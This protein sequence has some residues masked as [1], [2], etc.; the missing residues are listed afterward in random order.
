LLRLRQVQFDESKTFKENYKRLKFS[1]NKSD[2]DQTVKDLEEANHQ[3]HTIVNR[4]LTI[5]ASQLPLDFAHI[6]KHAGRLHRAL[7][8]DPSFQESF[9][10]VPPAEHS[11]RVFLDLRVRH[12]SKV[13]HTSSDNPLHKP[14]PFHIIFS[15]DVRTTWSS[16]DAD[17][18]SILDPEPL[19]T[20]LEFIPIIIRNRA[21]H[22]YALFPSQVGP[23]DLASIS[24]LDDVLLDVNLGRKRRLEIGLLAAHGLLQLAGTPWLRGCWTKNIFIQH[25]TDYIDVSKSAHSQKTHAESSNMTSS[26]S[27]TAQRTR[28]DQSYRHGDVNPYVCSGKASA[29]NISVPAPKFLQIPAPQPVPVFISPPSTDM[30]VLIASSLDSE[31]ADQEVEVKPDS[32][33]RIIRNYDLYQLGVLL[34][35]LWYGKSLHAL[36]RNEDGPLYRPAD[37]FKDPGDLH[38]DPFTEYTTADLLVDELYADAGDKYSDAV[39]R[40]IRCDFEHRS[41]DLTDPQL[42]QEVHDGVYQTLYINYNFGFGE[43]SIAKAHV[44]TEQIDEHPAAAIHG[45]GAT[46]TWSLKRTKS[47]G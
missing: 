31:T 45:S 22:I 42:L 1:L 9:R 44:Q 38:V 43:D 5:T 3:L 36:Y 7:S 24:R 26:S 11:S 27:E 12:T 28:Q 10:T 35:E 21:E 19:P 29:P 17:C 20:G 47:V 46:R 8:Q 15:G 18:Y 34:I 41:S 13:A 25:E 37:L 40:C 33:S 30:R 16:N 23:G 2:Y 32:L 14:E 6:Q 4:A 39:R